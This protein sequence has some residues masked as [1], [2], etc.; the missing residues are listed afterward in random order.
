ML[1]TRRF[2][3][4]SPGAYIGLAYAQGAGIYISPH[5]KVYIDAST[6]AQVISNTSYDNTATF[7]DNIDGP[8]TPQNC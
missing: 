5:A 2:R 1:S 8:Y 4:D 3:R 7:V 6:L